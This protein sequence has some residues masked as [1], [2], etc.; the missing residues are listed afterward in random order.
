MPRGVGWGGVESGLGLENRS[1][2]DIDK[3]Q[4][5]VVRPTLLPSSGGDLHSQ[6]AHGPQEPVGSQGAVCCDV[7]LHVLV[8]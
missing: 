7:A 6:Q 8:V 2:G 3:V 5:H 4:S 1:Q